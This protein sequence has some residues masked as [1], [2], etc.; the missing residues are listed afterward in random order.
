M[1]PELINQTEAFVT[2][3]EVE[4]RQHARGRPRERER[5]ENENART[6]REAAWELQSINKPLSRDGAAECDLNR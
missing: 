5:E 6:G 2:L 4:R 3:T 1:L